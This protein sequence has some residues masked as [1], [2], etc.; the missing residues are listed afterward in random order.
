M[1]FLPEFITASIFSY[2]QL[3]IIMIRQPMFSGLL[4]LAFALLCVSGCSESSEWDQQWEAIQHNIRA[5]KLSQAHTQLQN[6]LPAIRENG[7]SD[8]RY[9]QI[10][11]QLGEIARLE[12]NTTQAESYYWKALPLIA[13]SLGPEHLHMADPLTELATIYQHNGQPKIAA[14]LLKRALA[15]REKT[16]GTSDRQLLPTLKHY[17]ILLML[18]DNHE[19]AVQIVTRISHLEQASF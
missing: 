11:Y 2:G 8:T 12:G 6:I 18:I 3:V 4:A 14:P 16:W 1:P 9:A 13:Q 15:I 17:H 10:I 5:G 19:E 7:P